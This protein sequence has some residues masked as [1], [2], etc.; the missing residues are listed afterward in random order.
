MNE[1]IGQVLHDRYR[2]QSL[3]GKQTGRRTFLADDLESQSSVVIK[4]LL[5]GPDFTWDDLKLFEREAETLKRLEHPCI[6]Q[7]LDS[8]E[9]ETALGKGFALVQSYIDAKSLKYWIEAGR[10]FSE[11]ELKTIA[12]SLLEILKSLHQHHR[13]VVVQLGECFPCT[14]EVVGSSPTHSTTVVQ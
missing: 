11:S 6:P 14:E 8:F 2:V 1:L 9:I 5:F 7:Y 12:H 10:S 3:L 4:L 13:G